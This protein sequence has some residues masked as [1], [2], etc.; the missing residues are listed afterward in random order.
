V[1]LPTGGA[2]PGPIVCAVDASH[3]A[4]EALRVAERLSDRLDLPLVVAHVIDYE[5]PSDEAAVEAL[6]GAERL[7]D[8]VTREAAARPVELRAELGDPATRLAELAAEK[9]AEM[10]IIGSKLHGRRWRPPLR[11]SLSSALARRSRCPILVVPPSLHAASRAEEI[12]SI[13]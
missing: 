12:S 11:S 7:L 9:A 2:M 13:A 6:E 1:M 8:R 4:V 3:G 5:P 10:I